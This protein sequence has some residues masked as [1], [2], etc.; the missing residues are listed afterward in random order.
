[1]TRIRRIVS[2]ALYGLVAAL[3]GLVFFAGV[4]GKPRAI[5]ETGIPFGG[6]VSNTMWCACS[7]NL[8]VTFNNLAQNAP[9]PTQLLYQPGGTILHPYGQLRSGAWILGNWGGSATCL[10]FCGS[11]GCCVVGVFPVMIRVGTSM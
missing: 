1:M 9:A 6:M 8:L 5:A 2:F 3:A 7:G 11:P 4:I 10:R